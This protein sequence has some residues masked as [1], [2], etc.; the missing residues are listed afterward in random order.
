M[1][2]STE[3]SAGRIGHTA[4]IL[5]KY[6]AAVIV[7]GYDSSNFASELSAAVFDVTSGRELKIDNDGGGL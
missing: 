2:S 7:G 1:W 4:T 3:S 6:H 5:G